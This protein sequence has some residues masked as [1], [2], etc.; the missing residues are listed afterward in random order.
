M[1]GPKPLKIYFLLD[2]SL[3]AKY[4]HQLLGRVVVDKSRPLDSYGPD[5]KD[6]LKEVVDNLYEEP[7]EFKDVNTILNASNDKDVKAS[8]AKL[9]NVYITSQSEDQREV[10]APVFRRYYMTRIEQKFKALMANSNY[11]QEVSTLWEGQHESR[12][13]AL[14]T[15]LLTCQDHKI[16][17]H[18]S[19][20]S[21][22]GAQLEV[23]SEALGG[24]PPGIGPRLG[25]GANANNRAT[26]S[27]V[28]N[29]EMVVAVAYHILKFNK[30][31]HRFSSIRS[32]LSRIF[33]QPVRKPDWRP[34]PIVQGRAEGNQKAFFSKYD[35]EKSNTSPEE[36][37]C[38]F[39]LFVEKDH[40]TTL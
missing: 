5:I 6:D 8:V 27:A 34:F 20:K 23:P 35:T 16:D 10:T 19:K 15:G 17:I 26:S 21:T 28:A 13:L 14:V 25:G 2:E 4:T 3:H 32:I 31:N 9:L 7:V 1:G 18:Q 36:K 40:D 29:G 33:R 38:D 39:I 30:Q 22:Y 37:K 24:L 11:A 12:S